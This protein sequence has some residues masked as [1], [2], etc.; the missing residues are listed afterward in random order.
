MAETTLPPLTE[1]HMQVL[2]LLAYGFTDREIG[3]RLGLAA[4]TVKSHLR[5]MNIAWDTTGRTQL[6][7]LAYQHGVLPVT[8]SPQATEL[9]E[10]RAT[11]RELAE[12]LGIAG[13]PDGLTRT[14]LVTELRK[15]IAVADAAPSPG[16]RIRAEGGAHRG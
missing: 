6:V 16:S 12:L 5:R 14:A 8:H 13:C 4:Q 1:R 3:T 9:A 15:R 10:L 7:A 2:K 11:V